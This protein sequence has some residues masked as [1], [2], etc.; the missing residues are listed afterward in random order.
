MTRFTLRQSKKA[1]YLSCVSKK[2][3]AHGRAAKI[4]KFPDFVRAVKTTLFATRSSNRAGSPFTYQTN[5]IL[6]L[7]HEE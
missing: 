7:K 1:G 2:P 5:S 4:R 6:R 3:A